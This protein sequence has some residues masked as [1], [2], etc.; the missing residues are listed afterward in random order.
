MYI[1][2]ITLTDM[3]ASTALSA[4]NY[5][6]PKHTRP[7]ETFPF[8][9]SYHECEYLLA[10]DREETR[11]QVEDEIREDDAIDELIW[12]DREERCCGIVAAC[13]ISMGRN[14]WYDFLQI[15][16]VPEAEYKKTV[17]SMSER[18]Q[19]KLAYLNGRLRE[20]NEMENEEEIRQI[21]IVQAYFIEK[22]EEM[23]PS[24]KVKQD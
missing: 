5:V 21:K 23:H 19:T 24:S 1:Y 9:P 10:M 7:T 22:L 6:Q 2:N 13:L 18:L 12:K 15:R 17:E 3:F 14:L 11:A 8:T 20:L 16:S 4:A